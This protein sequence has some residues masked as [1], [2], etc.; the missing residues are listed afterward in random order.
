[1]KRLCLAVLLCLLAV[2]PIFAD[3]ED[4]V[5]FRTRMLPDNEVPPVAAAGNSAAAA[6]TVH[7]TRDGRGNVNSATVT[8]DIDYTVT[9][10]TTFTGLRMEN[11]PP[12]QNGAVAINTNISASSPVAVA[13]GSGRISRTV[14]YSPSD[15]NGLRF[16]T[17][18]LAMPQ[19]Y[20]VNV[21][22]STNT[23]GFMR[24]QL[25][26][27][28]LVLRPVMSPRLEVPAV[29]LDAEGAALIEVQ[30]ERNAQTGAITSGTVMFEINYRFPGA[31][32][33]TGVQLRNAA[34]GANGPS[35]I[36]TGVNATNRSITNT[37][38]AGISTLFRMV[39]VPGTDT[40]GLAALT[41]LMNDPSQYYI[42]MQTS[43][44]PGGA[45]R[46]QLSRNVQVFF[47]LMT[48]AE[49][50]PPVSTPG[51]SYSMTYVRADRD[52]TGNVT[53]GAVSFNANFHMGFA[54]VTFVGFHIHNGR[55]GVGAGVV[56]STGIGGG[57]NSVTFA[58]GTG[59]INREIAVDP[60]NSTA[61]DALRGLVENP[62][63]YYVNLHTP[64]F[65]SGIVRAQLAM[66]KYRFKVNLSPANEVPPNTTNTSATAWI[67]ATVNRDANR[68]I[69]GGPVIFDVNYTGEGEM[70]FTGLHIHHPGAA[71]TVAPAIINTGIGGGAN[72]VLSAPSGSGNLTRVAN[73]DPSSAVQLAALSALITSPD[74][75]Y[76]N[77]HT[78]TFG[79][80]IARNQ[81]LGVV[82]IVPQAVG[83]GDW[84]SS[85][86]IKNPS[87]TTAVMGIID[88]F[89]SSGAV[90]PEAITDPNISFLIPPS[91]SATFNTTNTGA[92]TG[93]YVKVFS[94]GTVNVDTRYNH[95]AFISASAAAASITSR[96]VS[97]PV[98][99]GNTANQ[100]TGVAIF[101]GSAGTLTLSLRDGSGNAIAG[102][103]RTID[104]TAG[105]QL[106]AFVRELLPS[107]TQTQFSGTLT[108]TAGAG[109]I[110]VLAMQFD[111]TMTPVT[112]TALP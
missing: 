38:S 13:S 56:I 68:T 27:Y 54:P 33:I 21:L 107:V 110:S 99:V 23:T 82:N 37:N 10:A 77:I 97:V 66:E 89:Q 17:G 47:N 6:I 25:L 52:S 7:V 16:V 80:G 34:A 46:G 19:N 71:L 30:V 92:L 76:V 70:T 22:T 93:G 90:M 9:A 86:T 3:T 4:T 60:S 14:N 24:G 61:F 106:T 39:E 2:S 1:M 50:T 109:T 84:I 12:G 73:V 62:E 85:I 28:R 8:F 72:S 5:V 29:N 83:G 43:A 67:T 31:V 65:P 59:S 41:G 51:F 48:G 87:S 53:G 104:V 100:N 57:A 96:S 111:G 105:Q 102:G 32:T 88:F 94:S 11:A 69:V 95:P 63:F 26:P 40:A 101:A 78:T 35:V 74:I 18:L 44:N 49:E 55:F 58:S 91:G 20:Y 108:I 112:V 98:A 42:D 81:T 79:G 75:T 103:S 64:E 36:D 15:A 45:L